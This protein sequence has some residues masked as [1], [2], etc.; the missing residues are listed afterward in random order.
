VSSLAYPAP[1]CTDVVA[2]FIDDG[3]IAAQFFGLPRTRILVDEM[4]AARTLSIQWRAIARLRKKLRGS[5]ISPASCGA[6]DVI[7]IDSGNQLHTRSLE[8]RKMKGVAPRK[9][10]RR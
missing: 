10:I 3:T 7:E 1:S 8:Y 2:D 9:G 4:Q 6:M 5:S